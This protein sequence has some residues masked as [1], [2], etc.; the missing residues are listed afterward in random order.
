MAQEHI[1]SEEVGH[2]ATEEYALRMSR[3]ASTAPK[4]LT[5]AKKSAGGDDNIVIEVSD[6]GHHKGYLNFGDRQSAIDQTVDDEPSAPILA[7]DEVAKDPTAQD[8]HPA[9]EPL[10]GYRGDD[11]PKSR[12]TS[13]PASRPTS[14]P[15]SV[16]SPPPVELQSTPL[17]DVKEYE[18]LF[19]DDEKSDNKSL[20]AE[21]PKENHR[22]FPSRDVWEDAP[23][24]VHATAEVSTPEVTGDLQSPQHSIRDVPSRENETPAQAFARKQEELA[25][26]E[27][28][29]PDSFLYRQQKPPTYVGH[30]SH[31]AKKIKSTPSPQRF[32]SR[33]IWEDTPDSLQ[34]TTTVS[35]PESGENT[36][37]EGETTK[38]DGPA[39]AVPSRPKKQS[40]GDDVSSKPSIPERPAKTRK[41]AAEPQQLSGPAATQKPPVPAKPMGGK[42][43]ALQAGFMSDLNKRLQLGPQAPKKEEPPAASGQAE[44]KEKVPLSDA[45]KSRAR[46]PQRRAPTRNTAAATKSTP[47]PAS[48]NNKQPVLSFSTTLTLFSIDEEG[49]ITVESEPMESTEEQKKT[50]ESAVH[51]VELPKPQE[52]AKDPEDAAAPIAAESISQPPAEAEKSVEEESAENTEAVKPAVEEETKTLGTNTAGQHIIEETIEK[53]PG[54]QVEA[55]ENVKSEVVED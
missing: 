45:R 7:S 52:P 26:K 13:R 11:E 39:P 24:S 36:P 38:A 42:I 30:Q 21:R 8:L 25:E 43:A 20:T 32:P 23:D 18:P 41:S 53:K 44:E 35:G 55:V 14:R 54:D 27:S 15:T 37:P 48:A 46:G 28:V 51:E 17:D 47:P 3:P 9:V 16:Y 34:Y 4:D 29:N 5:S 6:R 49:T 2:Q 22:R 12:P 40:S 19:T 1:P 31:I 50:V 10:P 33:D